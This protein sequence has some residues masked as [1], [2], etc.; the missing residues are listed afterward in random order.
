MHFAILYYI[1][2]RNE[3]T[4]KR[5]ISNVKKKKLGISKKESRHIHIFKKSIK[6]IGKGLHDI[7][8]FQNEIKPPGFVV[9]WW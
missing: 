5:E 3:Y 2:G 1:F 8:F 7:D 9:Q 6:K 4:A